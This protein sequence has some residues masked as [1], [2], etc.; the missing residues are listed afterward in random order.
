MNKFIGMGILCL[1]KGENEGLKAD[2][3][4]NTTNPSPPRPADF[5]HRRR[6]LLA[7]AGGYSGLAALWILSKI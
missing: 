3:S 1:D 4:G 5:L 7:G 2:L 6:W